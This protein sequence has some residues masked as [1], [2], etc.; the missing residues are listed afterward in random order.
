[1]NPGLKKATYKRETVEG[2]Q[3]MDCILDD[4]KVFFFEVQ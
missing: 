1:M 3:N 2:N 4:T